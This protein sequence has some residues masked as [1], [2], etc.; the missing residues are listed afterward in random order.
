MRHVSS[1]YFL[2]E[3]ILGDSA[4]HRECM[5]P[6]SFPETQVVLGGWTRKELRAE[7]STLWGP[8]VSL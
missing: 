4:D 7:Q 6:V 8:W 5:G 1:G 2:R 3:V